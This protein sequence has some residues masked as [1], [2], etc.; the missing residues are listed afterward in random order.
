ML[1]VALIGCGAHAET[2][3]A[4]P[5]HR[6]AAERPDALAL[7]ACCDLQ[8]ERAERFRDRYGFARADTDWR[9]MLDA[10]RPDAAFCVVP[11]EQTL[12]VGGALLRRGIP[13]VL[14]KPPGATPAEVAALRG[15][16][17]ETGTPHQVSVNRRFSPFLNRALAWAREEGPVR[18]VHARMLR[19]ARREPDFVWGTGV[20]VVD[21]L[22]HI[23]GEWADEL[24]VRPIG[25]PQ[26]SAPWFLVTFRFAS[27]TAGAIEIAPTAGIVEETYELYGDGFRA[28]ATTM[29]GPDGE[30]VRCWRNGTLE[31]DI[32]ADPA[33]PPCRRDGSWEELGAFLDALRAGTSPR[34]TV[35]DVAP[36][37]DLCAR[38]AAAFDV[39]GKP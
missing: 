31:V 22:R 15:I 25:P 9:T 34:P 29:G 12:P 16:A 19:N 4:D 37:M 10:E 35:E 36:T 24:D 28:V 30:S 26:T 27:G 11:I 23:G 38:I 6:Y 32:R 5:L 13:C 3:H 18:F 33:A 17:R 1:R 14:E 21:A 20:H 7:A 2:A 39:K 8:R